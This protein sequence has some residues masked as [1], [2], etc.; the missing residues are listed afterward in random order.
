MLHDH[1]FSN[2]MTGLIALAGALLLALVL[3]LTVERPALRMRQ[4]LR[5]RLAPAQGI[6]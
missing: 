4:M 6:A 3:T 2:L 5:A 1:G